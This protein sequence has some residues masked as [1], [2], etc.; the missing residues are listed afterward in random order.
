MTATPLSV[1]GAYVGTSGWSYPSW[2]PAFYPAELKPTEFLGHY[3]LALPTVELNTTGYRLPA[4]GQFERWAEQTP[5]GFRFAPKLVAYRTSQVATFE[6]RVRRLG[7][8]LGPI[9]VLVGAKRDEGFLTLLLGSLDPSLRLA[10]DFRHE[11]WEGVELPPNAV[12]VDDLEASADFRY[13]RFRDPPYS[14]TELRDS[15]H[16][17]APLLAQG[18]Q[19]YGLHFV[20]VLQ[21]GEQHL[22]EAARLDGL[23]QPE[24]LLRVVDVPEIVSRCVAVD[25]AQLLGS[26]Q[27]HAARPARGVVDALSGLDLEQMS[28]QVN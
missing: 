5:E 12:C 11:S 8:R 9:R 16:R 22:V 17:V 25:P 26:R 24:P 10:F 14:E 7:D 2:K 15:A 19:H 28:H 6:E 27:Q 20:V 18:R 23:A 3:A 1:E 13:L 21:H 4:E